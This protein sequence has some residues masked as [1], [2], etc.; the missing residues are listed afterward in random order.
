MEKFYDFNRINKEYEKIFIITGHLN[1]LEILFTFYGNTESVKYELFYAYNDIVLFKHCKK[2]NSFEI[3]LYH[4]WQELEDIDMRSTSFDDIVD[5]MK[6]IV[7][8]YFDMNDNI[9]IGWF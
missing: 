4:I 6:P 5:N 3:D 8:K 1:E 9:I 7:K 2:D